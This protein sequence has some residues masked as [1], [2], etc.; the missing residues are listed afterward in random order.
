MVTQSGNLSFILAVSARKT[1]AVG[2]PSIR[3]CLSG[4]TKGA[5]MT[6]A[7]FGFAAAR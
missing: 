5:A 7:P 1:F 3:E 4:Q 2:W 6:A